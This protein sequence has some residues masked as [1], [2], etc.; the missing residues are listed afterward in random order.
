MPIF[1]STDKMYDVLGSLFRTLLAD[2]V[3][4]PQF[5]KSDLTIYFKITDPDGEL[6]V[7]K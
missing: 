3:F 4:G 1:E 6:W 5:V 7:S 2:P